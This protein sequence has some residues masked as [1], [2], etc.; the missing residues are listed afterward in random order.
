MKLSKEQ[1]QQAIDKLGHP[2]GGVTLRCD[3]YIVS[4]SIQKFGKRSMTFRVMTYINGSFDYKW[5]SA[6]NEAPE[7]RLLR[8]SVR[9]NLSPAKRKQAEKAL[10]KRCVAKDP[11]FSGSTTLYLPDWPNGSAV[12]NHLCKVCESVKVLS[13][14]EARAALAALPKPVEEAQAEPEAALEE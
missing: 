10:G 12:I 7:Q 4:L 14:E 6:K 11:I 1:K 8:K 2:W 9:P 5:M 3:G 13:H